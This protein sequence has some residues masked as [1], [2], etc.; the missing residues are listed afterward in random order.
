MMPLMVMSPLRWCTAMTRVR[1]AW[2][3]SRLSQ[4]GRK[5]T[6]AG[7]AALVDRDVAQSFGD[8]DR[9]ATHLH[10]TYGDDLTLLLV[11]S[12]ADAGELPDEVD[13]IVPLDSPAEAGRA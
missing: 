3:R 9:L 8:L 4:G 5:R 11:E 2:E 13:D 7:A 12:G 10:T 1:S 6:G